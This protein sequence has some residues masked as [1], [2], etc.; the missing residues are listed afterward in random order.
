M[1][2]LI[3]R[4]TCIVSVGAGK[5]YIFSSILVLFCSVVFLLCSRCVFVVFYSVP[6]VFP[7]SSCSVSVVFLLCSCSVPFCSVVSSTQ[8]F[9]QQ[10]EIFY[11][12]VKTR[13]FSSV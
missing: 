10:R 8:V 1:G 11:V 9:Q 3:I 4:L 12:L 7:L 5:P 13:V 2:L 6:V